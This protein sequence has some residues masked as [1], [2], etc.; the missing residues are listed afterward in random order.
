M[1]GQ[2]SAAELEGQ[3]STLLLQV[4]A[5][6]SKVSWHQIGIVA[7]D[8]ANALRIKDEQSAC[9]ARPWY[10]AMLKDCT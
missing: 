10:P 8:I 6:D 5:S 2:E 1:S 7:H 9:T 3:L 4:R